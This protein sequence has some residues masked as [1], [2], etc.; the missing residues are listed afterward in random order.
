[1]R[2]KWKTRIRNMAD[3]YYKNTLFFSSLSNKKLRARHN[4]RNKTR[5]AGGLARK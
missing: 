3:D 1:L 2:I 5:S 4:A